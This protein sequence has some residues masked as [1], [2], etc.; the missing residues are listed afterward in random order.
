MKQNVIVFLLTTVLVVTSA[1]TGGTQPD[2]VRESVPDRDGTSKTANGGDP[3]SAE[4]A[5][6]SCFQGNDERRKTTVI[7]NNIRQT[8]KL[9]EQLGRNFSIIVCKPTADSLEDILYVF[10]RILGNDTD[11]KGLHVEFQNA[12]EGQQSRSGPSTSLVDYV[13]YR[14]PSPPAQQDNPW[15]TMN[16]S[17]PGGC[18]GA[19]FCWEGCGPN[20]EY[21]NGECVMA[22]MCKEVQKVSPSP[23]PNPSPIP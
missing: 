1:C 2:Q 18:S 3:G 15:E 14:L 6:P 23:T 21:C 12:I 8:P 11:G 7:M 5:R 9:A 4:L 17:L 13:V 16:L 10:G 22:G 20:E 19:E